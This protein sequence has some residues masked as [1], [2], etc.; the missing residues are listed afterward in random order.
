MPTSEPDGLKAANGKCFENNE[1][2]PENVV[3][4]T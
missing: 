3:P 4:I 1:R 2:V